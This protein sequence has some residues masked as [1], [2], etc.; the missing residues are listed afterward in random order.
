MSTFLAI[1]LIITL[2]FNFIAYFILP[3]NVQKILELIDEMN[4]ELKK[5]RKTLEEIQYENRRYESKV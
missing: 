2:A 4:E 1:I 5:T 3:F